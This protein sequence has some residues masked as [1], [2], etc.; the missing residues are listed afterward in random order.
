M[1]NPRSPA[2]NSGDI[3]LDE[4]VGYATHV[5]IKCSPASCFELCG[6]SVVWLTSDLYAKLPKCRTIG[7]FKERLYCSR[8]KHRGWV[9]IEA[10]G[11]D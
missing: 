6:R 5:R 7:E 11:R 8:C 1:L 3:P 10:A 4:A 2:R 9:T